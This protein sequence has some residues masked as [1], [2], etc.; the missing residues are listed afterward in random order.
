MACPKEK[1]D[2][3]VSLFFG[4]DGSGGGKLLGV[5]VKG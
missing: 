1:L 3:R 5:G 2:L 4:G